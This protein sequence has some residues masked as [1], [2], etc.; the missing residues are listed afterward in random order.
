[1]LRNNISLIEIFPVSPFIFGVIG[2]NFFLMQ[3]RG[4]TFHVYGEKKPLNGLHQKKFVINVYD[5]IT[6]IKLVTIS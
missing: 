2:V 3:T 1:M 6:H 4:C 5:I